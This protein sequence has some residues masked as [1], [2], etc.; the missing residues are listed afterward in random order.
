MIQSLLKE[1]QVRRGRTQ[2]VL[3]TILTVLTL[4]IYLS[5]TVRLA[6]FALAVIVVSAL[7]GFVLLSRWMG[8]GFIALILLSY[9][10][11]YPI[12]TGT[13]VD[14]NLTVFTIAG[15]LAVWVLKMIVIDRKIRLQPSRLN[16]PAIAFIM[17]TSIS[18]IGG[19]MNWVPQA[20]EG[21]TL[22]A[23][24]GGWTLYVLSILLM[25]L[26]GNQISD[27]RWLKAIVWVFLG[28]GG[29]YLVG[30]AIQPIGNYTNKIFLIGGSSMY[31]CWVA[32]LA[33]GQFLCN[34]QLR[35]R[36]R[37]SLLGLV[38][39]VIGI[40]WFVNREWVSGWLPV[41]VALYVITWLYNWRWGLA[42]SLA[43]GAYIAID[44]AFLNSSVMTSTQQY[45]V[46]SRLGTLPVMLELIKAS[47]IIGL[48]P[49]NYYHYTYLYPLLGWYV[50]FN[51][52]NNY[53]DIVAQYG[54]LGMAVFIWLMAELGFLG[55]RLRKHFEDGFSR[56]YICAVL[57]GMV[58]MLVSGMM[59]DWF[60]PFLYNIGMNG[61]RGSSA[62]WLFMGG[63]LVLER[64]ARTAPSTDQTAS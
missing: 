26:A 42:I 38:A 18:L 21:A 51:S 10:V 3:I 29:V 17:V 55:L 34:K 47:P 11:G 20:A 15:L 32:A 19:N 7:V 31:Y 50:Q 60:L 59:G 52:H 64:L 2:F 14:L 22:L 62:A 27:L 36:Y 49:S 9:L 61:F 5:F 25:L 41:F 37:L 1:W 40:S 57:G 12:K 44:Y 23:Q 56:G 13:N 4:T 30:R 53:L 16:V 45:S 24:L 35:M 48:G 63:L 6:Y 54:L 8:L 33:Y 46:D 58:G 28:I 43:A 39:I